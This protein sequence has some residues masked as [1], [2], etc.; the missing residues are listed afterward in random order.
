MFVGFGDAEKLLK[1]IKNALQ[2]QTD[3]AYMAKGEVFI[4]SA[5]WRLERFVLELR[6]KKGTG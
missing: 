5:E 4:E 1:N 3:S 2:E 6:C